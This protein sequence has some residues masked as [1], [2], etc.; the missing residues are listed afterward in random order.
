MLTHILPTTIRQRVGRSGGLGLRKNAGILLTSGLLCGCIL[1]LAGCNDPPEITTHRIPKSQSGLEGLRDLGP[2]TTKPAGTS[3][4]KMTVPEG[5][6][7]GATNSM[8][9]NRFSKQID[10][11]TVEVTVVP[12]PASNDWQSN[13]VRW[14][15]QLRLTMSAEEIN[16]Q[17]TEV[18]I[19]GIKGSRIGLFDEEN[20][21]ANADAKAIVGVMAVQGDTAWFIKMMGADAAVKAA[22]E[23]FDN[24]L[25]T[26]KFP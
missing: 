6:T 13:V 19:D 7:G 16:E 25:T 8:V 15:G 9:V 10:G 12:L 24:Y 20:A 11:D 2:E 18:T 3:T 17:T 22:E 14:T 5:W 26:F 23:D 4:A 1:M 21:D